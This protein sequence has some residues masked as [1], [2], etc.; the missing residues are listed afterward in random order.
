VIYFPISY[1]I[2][3]LPALLLWDRQVH[4]PS[5]CNQVLDLR[6]SLIY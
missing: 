3:E 1:L 4:P 2:T 6:L 5:V